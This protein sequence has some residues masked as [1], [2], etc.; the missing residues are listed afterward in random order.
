[1]LVRK[2]INKLSQKL[3]CAAEATESGPW[4]AFLMPSCPKFALMLSGSSVLA[5][6]EFAGPSNAFHLQ[7][8]S[9]P[10]ISIATTG[11]LVIKWRSSLQN[12]NSIWWY[13][14]QIKANKNIL[15]SGDAQKST[16]QGLEQPHLT[17]KLSGF[18]EEVKLGHVQ[19]LS[20]YYDCRERIR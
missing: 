11:P 2:L 9:S 10:K 5:T 14:L 18:G 3:T 7:T 17:L 8:A 13:R 6:S 20:L 1:M 16:Q 19:S 12:R 15:S 4:A